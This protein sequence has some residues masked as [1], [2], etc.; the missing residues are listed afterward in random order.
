MVRTILCVRFSK[1]SMSLI[2]FFGL[3]IVLS[4]HRQNSLHQLK[5]TVR[6]LRSTILS[7][8]HAQKKVWIWTRMCAFFN[9]V[10]VN[11]CAAVCSEMAIMI[12]FVCPWTCL[13]PDIFEWDETVDISHDWIFSFQ[14]SRSAFHYMTRNKREGL[15]SRTWSQLCAALVAAP[16]SVKLKDI[17]KF[18]KWVIKQ[19]NNNNNKR[20]KTHLCSNSSL[21]VATSLELNIPSTVHINWFVMF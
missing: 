12:D 16:H 9:C 18:T 11:C 3:N 19:P 21:S 14:S 7:P 5:S 4:S 1:T 8:C 2:A 20:R 15:T 6:L 10:T 13:I 17:F